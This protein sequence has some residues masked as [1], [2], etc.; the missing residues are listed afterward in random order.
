M[1]FRTDFVTNSSSSG[2][3][4]TYDFTDKNGESIKFEEYATDE[5]KF[6]T[7][8]LNNVEHASPNLR[9]LDLQ[10]GSDNVMERVLK[11]AAMWADSNDYSYDLEDI[12]DSIRGCDY[13]ADC[14]SDCTP[15]IFLDSTP[16]NE[17]KNFASK[18]R[19]D[20]FV[21]F[22]KDVCEVICLDFE[23]D[24]ED[25]LYNLLLNEFKKE[26]KKETNFF[27]DM[28]KVLSRI[29][30]KSIVSYKI[31]YKDLCGGEFRLSLCEY[32]QTL[33]GCELKRYNDPTDPYEM[34]T[35]ELAAY[36]KKKTQEYNFS[37][38]SIKTLVD[39]FDIYDKYHYCPALTV[40]VTKD[41]FEIVRDEQGDC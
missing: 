1:K 40:Q 11:V 33:L 7:Y 23:S 26:I 35:D 2:F 39:A 31:T 9:Y 29:P 36:I 30:T 6:L 17:F 41:G 4:I 18:T 27:D 3:V 25:E 14:Y 24:N 13:L 8:Y 22:I 20:H 38:E 37:E 15:H 34:D 19:E 10:Y 32:I 28:S 16:A 12:E 5:D 21:D